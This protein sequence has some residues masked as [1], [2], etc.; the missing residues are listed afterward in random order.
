M[1]GYFCG[2]DASTL[3]I[4]NVFTLN[5]AFVMY[6]NISE[7]LYQCLFC[8]FLKYFEICHT[9]IDNIF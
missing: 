4:E 6:N 5:L 2:K 9:T 3:L 8:I 1:D 7:N